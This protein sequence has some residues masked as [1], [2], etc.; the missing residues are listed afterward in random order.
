MKTRDDIRKI[1]NKLTPEECYMF[2]S[3]IV[4]QD[5]VVIYGNWYSKGDIQKLFD[6]YHPEYIRDRR[7]S[8]VLEDKTFDFDVFYR[9]LSNYSSGFY[10]G[11]SNDFIDYILPEFIIEENNEEV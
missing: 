3:E 4:Y 11:P 7:I 8:G 9:D 1:V 10:E 2:I 5:K 6:K